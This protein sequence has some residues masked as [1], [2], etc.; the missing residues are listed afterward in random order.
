MD[1]LIKGQ[2]LELVASE[3]LS[4]QMRRRRKTRSATKGT[5]LFLFLFY[6]YYFNIISYYPP[7]IT[8]Q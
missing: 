7:V 4:Q 3:T 8:L 1:E 6:V 5:L 2:E